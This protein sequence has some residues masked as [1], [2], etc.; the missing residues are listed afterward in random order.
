MIA[1]LPLRWQLALM[2]SLAFLM[3]VIGL[4]TVWV[5]EGITKA[6]TR[7]ADRVAASTKTAL[8]VQNEVTGLSDAALRDR[9]AGWLR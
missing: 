4:R 5:R 8:E 7:Q 9:A 6:Q 2:V 3:G 1:L